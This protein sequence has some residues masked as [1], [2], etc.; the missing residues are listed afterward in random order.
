MRP[1][2]FLTTA[3]II[4]F[5]FIGFVPAHAQSDLTPQQLQSMI[6]SGQARNALADLRQVLATHPDSGV[7]WYLVA[8]AQDA[9]GNESQ[10]RQAFAKA[11]QFAPGL[12]FARP[13]NVSA[14]Q[15]HLAQPAAQ[16]GFHI[17]PGLVIGVLVVLF[18]GLRFL[19]H[20][21]AI[22][23][24][25]QGG[26][27]A[28]FSGR[29]YSP[30]PYGAGSTAYGPGM[31]GGLGSSLLG[32]LAAGAGFAVGE[33]IIDGVMSPGGNQEN[34]GGQASDPGQVPDR[35]DGLMGSPGWDDGGNNNGGG[36]DAGG[37]W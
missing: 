9:V 23:F 7:A 10:A 17:N 15:A 1:L 26:Y 13:E 25:Y 16:I 5:V 35:D 12:P 6:A 3:L 34:F 21:R 29:P 33:R 36:F 11:E 14:L 31:G 32:G 30:N 19:S 18:L 24:G 37:G 20:R 4:I 2:T 27:T 22:P 8:E 28:G